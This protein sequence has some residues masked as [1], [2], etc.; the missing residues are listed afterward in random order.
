MRRYRHAWLFFPALVLHPH[1]GLLATILTLALLIL[2]S[3]ALGGTLPAHLAN[4]DPGDCVQPCWLGLQ[5]GG[6]TRA[7]ALAA[8][9]ANGWAQ[10]DSLLDNTPST[11]QVTSSVEF[12]TNAPPI[13]DVQMRFTDENMTDLTLFPRE[14]VYLSQVFSAFGPPSHGQVCQSR[15]VPANI[16]G[17]LV[18]PSPSTGTFSSGPQPPNGSTWQP[19][20]SASLFFFDG[21]VEVQA[22]RRLPQSYTQL[23][24]LSIS[25]ARYHVDDWLVSP[26]ML[27]VR[28]VYHTS[29]LYITGLGPLS[30]GWQ[31]FGT[32]GALRPCP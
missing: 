20:V 2:A 25:P 10:P 14:R 17:F 11:F 32:A 27:V 1:R 18:A 6:T 23:T 16:A 15:V 19:T 8:I 3:V 29:V 26:E 22:V 31:G 13:Y 24:A 5:P 28:I 9:E 4:L 12:R 21:A 30:P 7:Q